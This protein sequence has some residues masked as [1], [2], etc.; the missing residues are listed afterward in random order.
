MGKFKLKTNPLVKDVFA[1]YPDEV[2]QQMYN[3]RKLIIETAEE[4]DSVTELE[5]TLK[6]GE[7]AYITRHGS[8]LRID[9]KHKTPTEY[10]MYFQCTSR[11]VGTFKLLFGDIFRYAGNRALVFGLEQKIPDAEIRDCIKAA[12]TYHKVK[13]LE[14]LG[15]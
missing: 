5:E 2:K 14:T 11:L 6:W 1:K 13:H 15:I 3:L 12:L 4:S 9:W 7:P 10:A 8:T